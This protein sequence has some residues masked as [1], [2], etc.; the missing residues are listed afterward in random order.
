MRYYWKIVY[1]EVGYK[2]MMLFVSAGKKECFP[3]AGLFEKIDFNFP[4]V[5][6]LL[7]GSNSR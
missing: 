3:L 2:S 6:D 5:P 1:D 4:M 7:A